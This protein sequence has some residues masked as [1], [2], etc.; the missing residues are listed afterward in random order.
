MRKEKKDWDGPVMNGVPYTAP[1]TPVPPTAKLIAAA[2]LLDDKLWA[3]KRHDRCILQVAQGVG[4][5]VKR[6][7]QGFLTDSGHFLSRSVALL[8]ADHTGQVD[9]SNLLG[10]DLTSEDLW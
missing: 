3:N 5:L 2:V 7:M 1:P 8:V 9:A 6:D 10:C 4:K